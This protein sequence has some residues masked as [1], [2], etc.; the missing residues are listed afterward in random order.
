MTK[1]PLKSAGFDIKNALNPAIGADSIQEKFMPGGPE[2]AWKLGFVRRDASLE[3]IQFFAFVALKVMMMLLA[4]NF[5]PR[6]ISR[7]FD[8]LQP[9]FLDQ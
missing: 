2:T 4:R 7:N 5:I 9:A 6:R 8:R 3:L 1:Y